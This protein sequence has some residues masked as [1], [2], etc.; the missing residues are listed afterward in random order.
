L[1]KLFGAEEADKAISEYRVGARHRQGVVFWQFD[2][3]GKIR[4]GKVIRYKDDLHRD[5]GTA[6]KWVHKM[7]KLRD[8]NL[9]QCLFG[10]H[11]LTDSTK[12]V[13]IVESEKTA[14][15]ASIALPQYTW[16]ATGGEQNF[17][18]IEQCAALKKK[19]I[20]LLPDLKAFA[21][22]KAKADGLRVNLH[23]D[24]RV[25]D[26]LETSASDT[27]LEAGW[28]IADYILL[29]VTG[30][31]RSGKKPCRVDFS[32]TIKKPRL[33]SDFSEPIEEG[34]SPEDFNIG[35][36]PRLGSDFS[37]T[38]KKLRLG[39]DFSEPIEE[40]WSPEDWNIK[41]RIF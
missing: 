12:S 24:I 33:G 8:F 2:T 13:M 41:A 4:T 9:E 29:R 14:V 17:R 26:C 11:L 38:I 1:R 28:D 7:L 35:K 5:K 6:P 39:S 27:E 25:D 3:L 37:D 18:L 10:E 21:T 15:I 30:G 32:D 16:L 23:L 36:K 20:T 19:S 31:K 34:W 40:D 22:W